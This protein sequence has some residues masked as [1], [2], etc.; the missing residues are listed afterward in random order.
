MNANGNGDMD[1]WAADEA[2]RAEEAALPLHERAER[3]HAAAL[4]AR[5]ALALHAAHAT[6][7]SLG[8]VRRRARLSLCRSVRP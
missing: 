8:A 5:P 2:L 7:S 4:L 3:A 6:L 1:E